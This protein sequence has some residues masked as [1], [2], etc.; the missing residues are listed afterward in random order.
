MTGSRFLLSCSRPYQP[1]F[2]PESCSH[3]PMHAAQYS[4]S[5]FE[6]L[7]VIKSIYHKPTN[8]VAA[9]SMY[10]IIQSKVANLGVQNVRIE[11]WVD[12]VEGW[13]VCDI[14]NK[15]NPHCTSIVGCIETRQHLKPQSRSSST[16]SNRIGIFKRYGDKQEQWKWKTRYSSPNNYSN[17]W[18]RT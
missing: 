7:M 1:C 8:C 11:I 9:M 16:S 2:Q 13:F 15:Q 3:C 6:Y 14:I 5:S 4:W 18:C 17:E 12:T 10:C